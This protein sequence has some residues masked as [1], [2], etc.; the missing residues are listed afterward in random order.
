MIM[1]ARALENAAPS[2]RFYS[3]LLKTLE[4]CDASITVLR[5]FVG[6]NALKEVIG[7]PGLIEAPKLALVIGY[8]ATIVATLGLAYLNGNAFCEIA[9]FA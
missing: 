2:A 9:G 6:L 4:G 8:A 5:L 7:L 3:L 1:L